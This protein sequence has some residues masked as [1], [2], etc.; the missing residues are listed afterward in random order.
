MIWARSLSSNDATLLERS[1]LT[2]E[3]VGLLRLG[4]TSHAL[5]TGLDADSRE[6]LASVVGTAWLGGAANA[7]VLRWSQSDLDGR[8]GALG[9][10]PLVRALERLRAARP[11]QRLPR[12]MGIVNVTPDSFSDGGRDVSTAIAH[13]AQ[14]V[15]EGAQILDI[16]GESTRPG[17]SEV[18]VDEELRRV[19][20]VIEGLRGLGVP[21]SIDTRK[22]E[23]A[24]RAIVAG[25][26]IVNDVSGLR[27][28]AM[29]EVVAETGAIACVM[30]MRGTP[31]TMQVDTHYDDLIAEVLDGLEL[32]LQRAE[33]RGVPRARL[34]VDPG[35]GFGKDLQGNLE[36][37]R[38][39]NDFRLLGCE[40]LFGVSR[41][42]FLGTI[43]GHADPVARDGASAAV[44]AILARDGAVDVIRVHDVRGTRDAIAVGNSFRC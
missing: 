18:P 17:A 27:D 44:A 42:K 24:R 23:V 41:K 12:I 1:S 8:I 3:G 2:P 39:A 16:G 36:L 30:H 10:S 25:A 11:S 34:W 6:Q 37:L 20:P 28:D 21:L 5:V 33:R 32:A 7:V 26:S 43:S 19:I 13:G 4:L 14:L 35:V 22:H 9:P 40:V 29:I 15:R 31:Q 38:R